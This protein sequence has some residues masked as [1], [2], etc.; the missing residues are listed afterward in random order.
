[1]PDIAITVNG[2]VISLPSDTVVAV[3][4]ARAGIKT[5]RRS[6]SGQMRGPLCGMGV[7]GECRVT[8]DG[9]AHLRSCQT[10]CRPGMEI[11]TDD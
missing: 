1:M 7:C 4:L 5:S 10:L 9:V 11:K 8:I 6:R 3:A 2:Q